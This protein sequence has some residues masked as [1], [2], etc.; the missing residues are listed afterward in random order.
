[1]AI[2]INEEND[3]C[4]LTVRVTGRLVKA[5]YDR[6]VPQVERLIRERGK[7]R[8]LFEMHDFH[9]WSAG[10]AWEDLRF[11]LR[12]CRDIE[13]MAIVGQKRW[14]ETM[15]GF[16]RPFTKADIRYFDVAQAQEAREWLMQE[17]AA[18]I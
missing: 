17:V 15:A 5:D 12:H 4:T 8:L 13:R 11:G 14:Q 1:M 3:G 18:A 16:C 9:G 2:E 6:F 10:A 7:I